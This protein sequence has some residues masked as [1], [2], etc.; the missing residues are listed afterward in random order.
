R[1]PFQAVLGDCF[2][3]RLPRNDVNMKEI[4]I[5]YTNYNLWANTTLTD[6][7]KSI[8]SSLLDRELKSSFPSLRK[9]MHHIWGGQVVWLQRLSGE[10]LTSFPEPI[11]D[12][13]EFTKA[14]SACSQSFIDLAK[15]KDEKYLMQSCSYKAFVGTLYT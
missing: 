12:F 15:E 14:F 7:L 9:T 13:S 2:G 10:S 4:L 3:R 1:K 8:D 5:N 6:V 11:N